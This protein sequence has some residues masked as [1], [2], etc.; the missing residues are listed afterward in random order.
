MFYEVTKKQLSSWGCRYH[1]LSVGKKP[2][3]DLLICD[4]AINSTEF[5]END[6][7]LDNYVRGQ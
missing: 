3:Y 4:K 1:N 2:D 5:F 6:Q 7:R